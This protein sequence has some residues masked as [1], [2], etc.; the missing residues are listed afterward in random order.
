MRECAHGLTWAWAARAWNTTSKR[1]ASNMGEGARTCK[2]FGGE[3]KGAAPT[4]QSH[5]EA[6][7]RNGQGELSELEWCGCLRAG[8]HPT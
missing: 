4:A 3:L 7:N 5:N 2:R 8:G 6:E 1:G